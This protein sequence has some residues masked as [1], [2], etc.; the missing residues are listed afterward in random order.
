MGKAGCARLILV[1]AAVLLAIPQ[2]SSAYLDEAWLSG[3]D[4][5]LLQGPGTIRLAGMGDL[6]VAVEDEN[7]EVNLYD[8]TGNVAALI[9]DKDTRNA[10]AWGTYGKWVDVKDGFRWQDIGVWQGGAL[11]VLRGQDVYAGGA[12]VSTRILD[13][14]R[15]DSR[16]F[17]KSLGIAYPKSE[18]AYADTSIIDM[19]AVGT[20][21]Q[22]YY[23]HKMSDILYVGA[24]GWG[25]FESEKRPVRLRYEVLN[26]C[27]YMGAGAAAVVAPLK[28]LQ[29]G[30]SYDLGSQL[31]ESESNDAFHEDTYTRKRSV[32]TYSGHAMVDL[33]GKL[34]GVVNYRHYSYESDQTL[35]MNWSDRYLINPEDTDIH[36]KLTVGD[37]SFESDFVATRWIVQ[38]LGIPL[39]VSAY[40]D[41]LL[42]D[43]WYRQRPN[44]LVWMDDFDQSLDEWNLGTGASYE[45]MGKA[46]VAAEFVLNR[47]RLEDKTKFEPE[48][49]N[50]K[51]LDVKGGAEYRVLS[52]LALRAGYSR[53]SEERFMGV[54][55]YDY[56]SNAFSAGLGCFLKNDK[57]TVDVAFSQ[58]TTQPD[59]DPGYDAEAKY[60]TVMLYGRY[61]F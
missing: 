41:M 33:L 29:V 49:V 44:A 40:F 27:D 11:A 23:A 60:Q 55:E 18:V 42:E 56:V 52:W 1:T 12:S 47:G 37:E 22:G 50:F 30:A 48:D 3:T 43:S 5:K 35:L 61:L 59:K 9:L 34:R 25:D 13:F 19:E 2:L 58:K 6:T 17:R 32:P 54:P 51:T 28:W 46:L 39:K 10:D 20:L 16:L 53:S 7:N 14:M 4:V 38:G 26:S 36:R 21:V 45:L 31:V 24:R 15:I 57:L 8:F